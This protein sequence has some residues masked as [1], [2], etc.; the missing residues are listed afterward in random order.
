MTSTVFT[1]GSRLVAGVSGGEIWSVTSP[2]YPLIQKAWTKFNLK[3]LLPGKQV[4]LRPPSKGGK[5]P[6]ISQVLAGS[7]ALALH[8][9][10]GPGR[11][12]EPGMVKTFGQP[13]EKQLSLMLDAPKQ[14]HTPHNQRLINLLEQALAVLKH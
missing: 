3:L 4:V 7:P 8:N 10:Y 13:M 5:L 1:L 11:A 14:E 9:E 12:I 2:D 6:M